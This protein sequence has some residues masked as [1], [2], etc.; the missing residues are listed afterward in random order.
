[1]PRFN[2]NCSSHFYMFVQTK[3]VV[4]LLMTVVKYAVSHL[5]HIS[6]PVTVD[7]DWT[8]LTIVPVMVR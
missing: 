4:A 8:L 2:L 1:M 5:D 6:V 3:S 7:T